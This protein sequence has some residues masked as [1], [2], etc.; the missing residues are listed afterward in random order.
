MVSAFP[1]AVRDLY[2]VVPGW[3]VHSGRYQYRSLATVKVS[4]KRSARSPEKLTPTYPKL[5]WAHV[6][7]TCIASYIRLELEPP[8]IAV[9][10]VPRT[11][12]PMSMP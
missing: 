8:L 1:K 9:A 11:F 12:A 10:R 7:P 3:W 6:L 2:R 5:G 4:W